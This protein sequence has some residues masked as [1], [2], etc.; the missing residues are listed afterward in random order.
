M[1]EGLRGWKVLVASDGSASAERA[2]AAAAQLPWPHGSEFRLITAVDPLS[3]MPETLAARRAR[4]EALVDGARARIAKAGRPVSAA[5]V[6]GAASRMII[7]TASE[8]GATAIVVGARGFGAVRGMLVGS[9]S[10]AVARTAVCSVLVVESDLRTPLRAVMAVDGSADAR[11]AARRLGEVRAPGNAV[12]V[13]RVVEPPRV[14]SLGLL[15]R[16]VADAIRRE[17]ARATE[18]LTSQ[19]ERDVR[20]V[21]RT[22]GQAGWK[23]QAAVRVGLPTPEIVAAARKARAS[24]VGVGPRGVTG[25]ER[26]LLGSVT[27]RLLFTPGLS[28]FIG[29]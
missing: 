25:L 22:F 24:L 21:A 10:S 6:I 18:E 5:V 2:V 12:S 13:V 8:W 16:G 17:V 7:Q 19:A 20:E 3:D 4:A 23:A 26:L 27:E 1:T 14:K 28:L 15:P 11:E 9:V 29:R